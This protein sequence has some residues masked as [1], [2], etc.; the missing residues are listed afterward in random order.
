[1]G[2]GLSTLASLLLRE[3]NRLAVRLAALNPHWDGDT[4]FLEARR[5]VA[6]QLQHITY[7]EFLPTVLGEVTMDSWDLTPREYG[8][9]TGYSSGVHAGALA[10]VGGAALH[11]FR[12]MVPAALVSNTTDASRL[13]ALDER[14]FT[15][16]VHAVTGSP[17][18]RPSLRM[19]AATHAGPERRPDWDP[20]AL[21]LHRGRDHGLAAY[22]SW[23]SF[24][25]GVPLGQKVD[26]SFLAGQHGLFTEEHLKQL[27]TVYKYVPSSF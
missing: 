14:R 23:L 7:S 2:S 13:D 20:L 5:L 12:T 3:H 24:C 18:L 26:F 15:H 11:A 10:S 1:M 21:L 9:Y 25:T 19:P 17:A 16:M 6:A 22:P 27:Q 4:L 8:H